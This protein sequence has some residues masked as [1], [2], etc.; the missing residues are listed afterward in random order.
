MG[1]TCSWGVRLLTHCN[2]GGHKPWRT[3]YLP[4]WVSQKI[5]MGFALAWGGSRKQGHLNEY[6][7]GRGSG[8]R[9]KLGSI[10]K[11]VFTLA[12]TGRLVV[13]I[14][15][16]DSG[17]GFVFV[18][19]RHS[20]VALSEV[21]FCR[22]AVWRILPMPVCVWPVP[23]VMA[24]FLFFF[25]LCKNL[26]LNLRNENGQMI[27]VRNWKRRILSLYLICYHW[28]FRAS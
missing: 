15:W 9:T 16:I 18:L 4:T 24:V 19:T 23:S 14:I 12:R 26:G 6:L 27:R 21:V 7:E 25:M 13:F 28:A 3:S 22:L 1:H 11:Q 5:L 10:R 20:Q 17:S 8:A 2:L